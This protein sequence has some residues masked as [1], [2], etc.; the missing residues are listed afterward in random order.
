MKYDAQFTGPDANARDPLVKPGAKL[1]WEFL[2]NTVGE[3]NGVASE[4]ERKKLSV[5]RLEGE[6]ATTFSVLQALPKAKVAHF[7]THGFFADP[8][9]RGI[10]QL[11]ESDY[12]KSWRGE[13]IGKAV[14]S[15]LVMTGLVCAGANNEGTPGRGIVTGEAL[16]D[17]DLS[18]L[19]LAVLSA[20]ETGIGDVEVVVSSA[21]SAPS[22]TRERRTWSPVCGRC[23]TP[24]RRH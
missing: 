1:G 14:N 16:I 15:P 19:E 17:L 8:S 20:C 11:D 23:P 6:K 4:A 2:P 13:R 9:F 24:R 18:G 3:L 21:S 10:F 12:E 22:T 5:T 7:A